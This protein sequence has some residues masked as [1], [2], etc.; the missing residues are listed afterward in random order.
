MPEYVVERLD[1]DGQLTS[2]D[3]RDLTDAVL[4]FQREADEYSP[5]LLIEKFRAQTPP[6]RAER[7]SRK[8]TV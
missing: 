4:V 5:F 6:F 1:N 3:A 7:K 2:S 8:G